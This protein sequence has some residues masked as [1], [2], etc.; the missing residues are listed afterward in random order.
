LIW[1]NDLPSEAGHHAL[2]LSGDWS[3]SMTVQNQAPSVVERLTNSP[4]PFCFRPIAS[5]IESRR[6]PR[7][8]GF[9][10][11][12]FLRGVHAHQR[13]DCFDDPLGVANEIAVDLLR[14]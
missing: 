8:Y 4:A 10:D 13:F 14:R 12:F 5:S 11:V 9:I 3:T 1:R 7:H 6:C 2:D